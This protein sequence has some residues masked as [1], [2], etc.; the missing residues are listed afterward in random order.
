MTIQTFPLV[1]N[2]YLKFLPHFSEAFPLPLAVR[3]L[4]EM[5]DWSFRECGGFKLYINI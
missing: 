1:L 2:E 5:C 4:K 3:I